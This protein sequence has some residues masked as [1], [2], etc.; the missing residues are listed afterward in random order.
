MCP[1]LTH[2]HVLKN[3]LHLFNLYN[4]T[5]F[6]PFFN[7]LKGFIYLFLERGGEGERE[8]EKFNVCLPLTHPLL[9]TRPATKACV[10]DWEL[11][12]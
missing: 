9:G 5:R 3:S 11:N 4:S 2:I 1:F 7:C 12:Q 10:L 6:Y 8:G